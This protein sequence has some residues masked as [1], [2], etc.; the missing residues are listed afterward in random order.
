MKLILHIG[1]H[2]TGTSSI[3]Q[4]FAKINE[5][6]LHKYGYRYPTFSNFQNKLVNHSAVFYSLF[7]EKPLN[8]HMNIRWGFNTS[9]KIEALHALYKKQIS[10]V[11]NTDSDTVIISGE[12][13]SSLPLEALLSLKHYFIN[14]CEVSEIEVICATREHSSFLKSDV[15]E[16]IK[17]G[18]G[19]NQSVSHVGHRVE[20]LYS[21]IFN[22]FGTVFGQKNIKAYKFEDS[23]KES[24]GIF[25]YFIREFLPDVKLP[26]DKELCTN[27]SL[28]HE[29]IELI[30]Y[31]NK[32]Q[33]LF[34]N[35]KINKDRSVN[36]T[37][38]LHKLNGSKFQLGLPD[39][40]LEKIKEDQNWLRESYGISYQAAPNCD[41]VFKHWSSESLSQVNKI[42]PKLN[43]VI[44]ALAIEFLRDKAISLENENLELAYELMLIAQ[45]FR[46]DGPVITKKMAVYA[47]K[48]NRN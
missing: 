40:L 5:S 30:S 47:R 14:E 4:N 28:S 31:I 38:A 48:L 21:S 26:K 2:K 19:I 41:E 16:Q 13:I 10:D 8:Y 9:K 11:F 17:G 12:G 42:I 1:I 3:Q 7:T 23:I 43:D 37:L 35:N 20:S 34:N 29:A 6:V 18:L 15:Q 36:D 32:R 33:P 27:E 46:P 25:N 24:K 45:T 39:A 44:R 22:K